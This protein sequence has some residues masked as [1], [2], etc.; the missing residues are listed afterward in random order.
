[1]PIPAVPP[2]ASET[3]DGRRM[4][5]GLLLTTQCLVVL[6][7]TA[8]ALA[9]PGIQRDLGF[10]PQDLQW[11]LTAYILGFGGL[12][13]LGGRAADLAGRRRVLVGGLAV[14]AL[15]SL[16]C[17]VAGSPL[18]LTV[19]RGVQGA[20]AAFAS[21]A[22]LSIV[23]VIFTG[24]ARN[25]ALGAWGIVS[26]ASASIGLVTGGIVT[27]VLGWRWSFGLIVPIAVATVLLSLR[28][29]PAL[30]GSGR[31]KPL[32]VA[33]AAL[34]TG[35]IALFVL[36]ISGVQDGG[37]GT[38][39]TSGGLLG[40]AALLAAFLAWERRAADPLV[41][42]WVLRTRSVVGTNLGAGVLGA[43][44]LGVFMIASLYLQDGLRHGPLE[45]GLLMLP[46]GAASLVAGGDVGR[47]V[48]R[49]G[50]RPVIV[51]GL[52]VL[53]GGALALSLAAGHPVLLSFA[54]ALLLFGVGI[55]LSEVS[56]LIGATDD[57][58][59]GELAGLASGLWS[60]SFQLFGAVGVALLVTIAT[61][62]P[63]DGA[64]GAVDG[65]ERATLV[66]AGIALAGA[67]LT[68]GA[69]SRRSVRSARPDRRRD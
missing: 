65:F 36:G 48:G 3:L 16:A 61:A 57:L 55:V 13:L 58:G 38:T 54:P 56:S 35:G 19:A 45:A 69:L 5:L 33:G 44:L 25:A 26:G 53:A 63:G 12:L 24:A 32:D 15:A 39:R 47:L 4:L 6:L 27:D 68:A 18:A 49:V 21:A 9:L 52:L 64:A 41:P 67:A 46:T 60:T 23:T 20:G 43:S 59:H 22:G 11:V 2:P 10:A 42:P 51:A 34:C 1:M 14:F 7:D 8:S 40:G 66:G 29:V 17:A 37:W 31:E 50:Y 62:H 30:P 28:F